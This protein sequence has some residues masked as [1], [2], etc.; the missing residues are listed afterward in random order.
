MFDRGFAARE[1][2]H[3]AALAQD[4]LGQQA[5]PTP[6]RLPVISASLPA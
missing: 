6:R 1:S 5:R 4:M 3:A 2:R